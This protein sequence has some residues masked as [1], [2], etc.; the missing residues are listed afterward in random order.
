MPITDIRGAREEEVLGTAYVA[1]LMRRLLTS[2]G[3]M[4]PLL[5]VLATATPATPATAQDGDIGEHAA[6]VALNIVTGGVTSLVAALIDGRDVTD[7]LFG[8]AVGGAAVF[9]GK[10]VA[11]Q[12]FDGAGLLGRELGAVGTG[13]VVNAGAGRPWLQ[14]I[15]L[16]V[17]PIWVRTGTDAPF[18]VR[19]SAT[20]LVMS[21]WAATR[22][23]LGFDAARSL[24]SGTLVFTSPDYTLRVGQDYLRGLTTSGFMV[25][26]ASEEGFDE[27]LSHEMI[28]VVQQDFML[29]AWSR[30][31]EA[32]AWATLLGRD[33]PVDVGIVPHLSPGPYDELREWESMILDGR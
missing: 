31:L 15:W 4:L 30:P 22:P 27:V 25:L 7:A 14:E 16:P 2:L 10:R 21:V 6:V 13:I 12:R 33:A 26:G 17:G 5:A 3:P 1:R 24:S 32:W 11:T 19:L 28:H 8:G 9:A 18:S 29:R 20:E 23:E